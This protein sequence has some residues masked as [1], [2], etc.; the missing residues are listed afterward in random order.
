MMTEVLQVLDQL[1][2]EQ[3]QQWFLF[4]ILAAVLHLGTVAFSGEDTARVTNEDAVEHIAQLL[5]V[6]TVEVSWTHTLYG[7][8]YNVCG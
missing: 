1:C 7:M 5:C 3:E 8:F 4:S 6:S 2:F